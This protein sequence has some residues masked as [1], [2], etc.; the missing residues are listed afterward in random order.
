MLPP[1]LRTRQEYLFSLILFSIVLEGLA[2]VIR[3][4]NEIK[5]TMIGKENAELPL[6]IAYVENPEDST[7]GK[8][9]E[10]IKMLDTG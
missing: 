1:T 2:R 7:K 9:K 4:D 6:L 8:R 5:V 10:L 3:D